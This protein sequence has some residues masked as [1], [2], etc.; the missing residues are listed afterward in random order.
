MDVFEMEMW[1]GV[2]GGVVYPTWCHKLDPGME[3]QGVVEEL[4]DAV[5]RNE[6]MGWP[7]LGMDLRD[8]LNES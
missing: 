3:S 4:V 7:R 8:L 1:Q 5:M 6:T 2:C